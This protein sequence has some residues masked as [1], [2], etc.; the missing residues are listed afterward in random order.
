M[1]RLV[2][3]EP[4]P[5]DYEAMSIRTGVRHC[6]ACD[7]DI[8]DLTAA[9]EEELRAIARSVREYIDDFDDQSPWRAARRHPRG[10]ATSLAARPEPT[11]RRVDQREQ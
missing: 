8:P 11:S 1:R 5:Q 2:M 9:T 7:R 4:C 6:D 10:C 3:V